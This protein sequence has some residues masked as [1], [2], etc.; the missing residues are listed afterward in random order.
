MIKSNEI[1]HL[2]KKDRM[3]E[4]Q[5]WDD[6]FSSDSTNEVARHQRRYNDYN[7]L[8]KNNSDLIENMENNEQFSSDNTNNVIFV[9]KKS[10]SD[11]SIVIEE[12]ISLNEILYNLVNNAN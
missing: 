2:L 10:K 1:T 7:H 4:T 11:K 12:K 5:E 9:H 3:V 6:M 8:F